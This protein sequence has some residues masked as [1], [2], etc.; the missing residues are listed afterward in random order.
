M[1]RDNGSYERLGAIE[2]MTDKTYIPRHPMLDRKTG[3]YRKPSAEESAVLAVSETIIREFESFL[4]T[5]DTGIVKLNGDSSCISSVE[6]V[7]VSEKCAPFKMPGAGTAFSFRI[8][9]YRLP[10][11]ADLILLNGTFRADAVLQLVA[12][13]QLGNI[14]IGEIT[15]ESPGIKYLVE[16]Q[17]TRDGNKFLKYDAELTQGIN[18]N[19][20]FYRKGQPVKLDTTYA[21]RSI[22]YRGSYL[23]VVDKITY[24]ELDFDRRRDVIV[25]FR[26][27]ETQESGNVT[28]AWKRLKDI[29]APKLNIKN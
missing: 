2:S 19:G 24:D 16:L 12:M 4:K 26:V 9:G 25:A 6:I 5:P 11:L 13:T 28:I 1:V 27:I 17:P 10:R 23:Q 3:I 14:P 18:A 15:L 8:D 21:L 7:N 22:A 20:Y 29:E